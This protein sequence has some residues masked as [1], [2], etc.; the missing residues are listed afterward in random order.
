[1][2]NSNRSHGGTYISWRRM[3]QRLNHR[4]DYKHLDM[5][6]RWDDFKVF[7]A[8][9]GERPEGLSLGRIDNSKGYWPWNCRWETAQEQANNRQVAIIRSDNQTGIKG[10]REQYRIE[11]L[12]YIAEGWDRLNK[13][14]VFLYSGSD[15]FEACCA[16]KSWEARL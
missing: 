2:T 12:R 9:M 16:R 14:T 8:D 5:D 10:V 3:R 13:K 11:G 7:L 6:P 15:F 4:F 1:M